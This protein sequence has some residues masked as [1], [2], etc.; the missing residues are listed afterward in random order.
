DELAAVEEADRPALVAD[1]VTGWRDGRI[2]LW[3]TWKALTARRAHRDLFLEGDYQPIEP[4][5]P[6]ERHCVAF[7]RRHGD[8][9]LVA[10][11]PRWLTGV[12]EAGR[13]PVGE[14][15][16]GLTLPLPDEAPSEW[17]CA[18]S[19]EAVAARGGG[20]AGVDLFARLPVALLL[21]PADRPEP[22]SR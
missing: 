19:G 10:A 2:K 17:R 20:L 21:A 18:L 12:T 1:L 8:R 9:W 11:V 16:E 14:V 7:A 13:P 6:L 4:T 3:T 22:S 5:G 15:W